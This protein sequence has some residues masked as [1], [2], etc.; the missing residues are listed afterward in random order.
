MNNAQIK[1]EVV[2]HVLGRTLGERLQGTA[3]L[4]FKHFYYD[5]IMDDEKKSAINKILLEILS[6]KYLFPHNKL[7]CYATYIASDIGLQEAKP[8]VEKMATERTLQKS[9][10]LL[11]IERA[12]EKFRISYPFT[13]GQMEEIVVCQIKGKYQGAHGGGD[14]V[15]D[16]KRFYYDETYDTQ[17][18]EM[19]K[20]VLMDILT[21][22]ATSHDEKRLLC[23]AAYIASDIGMLDAKPI[24]EN[25]ATDES[26][27]K[28]RYYDKIK[29]ALKKLDKLT[30]A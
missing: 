6:T 9:C 23:Y 28:F 19:I 3:P 8:Y 4:R 15:Y 25:I 11:L 29:H 30:R 27:K 13:L 5:K 12:L 17:K 1:K 21:T 2:T 26:L 18:K 16:F 14:A 24:I 7:R 22:K 10:L 20:K